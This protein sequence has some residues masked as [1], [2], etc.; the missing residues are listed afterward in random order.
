M[1]ASANKELVRRFVEEVLSGGRLEVID[2]LVADDAVDTTPGLPSGP[3]G[4]ER[5]RLHVAYANQVFGD[6]EVEI[7]DL[8]AEDDRV[9]A[10]WTARGVH[11][12]PAFG[13]APTGRPFRFSSVSKVTVRDGQVVGYE[14]LTDRLGFL[15]Q[16]GAAPTAA[17]ART[18][19]GVQP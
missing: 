7:D 14:A 1:S 13:V 11:A 10:F 18:E 8:V 9:V 17:R 15:E 16:V 19:R 12:G 6:L 5:F 4:R 3:G 2:E